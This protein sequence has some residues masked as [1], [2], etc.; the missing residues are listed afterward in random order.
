M[1][2]SLPMTTKK[3]KE[4]KSCTIR[5]IQN[6]SSMAQ[7]QTLHLPQIPIYSS[8]PV[9]PHCPLERRSRFKKQTLPSHSHS[10][11][12]PFQLG[13][14]TR[15]AC[16]AASFSSASAGGEAWARRAV[17]WLFST[18]HSDLLQTLPRYPTS[19]PPP[20]KAVKGQGRHRRAAAQN[21]PG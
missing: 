18:T 11:A 19:F 6:N 12:W 4:E 17:V 7:I 10:R 9:E 2:F 15:A 3:T 21:T 20:S 13:A 16:P 8:N 5:V 14:K 1:N